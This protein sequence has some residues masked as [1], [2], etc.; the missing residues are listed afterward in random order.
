ME[1]AGI[2]VVLGFDRGHGIQI[3]EEEGNSKRKEWELGGWRLCNKDA[4]K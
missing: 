2:G 3:R 4:T 1:K